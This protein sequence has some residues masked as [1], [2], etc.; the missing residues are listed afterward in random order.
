ME[1]STIKNGI[2]NINLIFCSKFTEVSKLENTCGD[3]L[4]K[5]ADFTK[6]RVCIALMSKA[7]QMNRKLDWNFFI[8]KFI[9]FLKVMNNHVLNK[10]TN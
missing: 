3:L 2:F 1:L 4:R 9:Y 6:S 8:L 10:R 7:E 5:F